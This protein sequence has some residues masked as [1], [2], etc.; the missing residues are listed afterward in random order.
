MVPFLPRFIGLAG[1]TRRGGRH[2]PGSLFSLSS[3]PLFFS[4]SLVTCS[5][6]L[7][8]K[9]GGRTPFEGD[10][11]VERSSDRDIEQSNLRSLN[12]LTQQT[13]ALQ[14]HFIRST[15]QRL[16]SSFLSRQFITPYYNLGAGNMS[17]SKLD[18]GTFRPNQYNTCV[19]L[20]HH[21]G[22]T[23]NIQ[24]YLSAV[25]NTDNIILVY[26]IMWLFWGYC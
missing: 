22:Q 3:F 8:Y 13:R 5:L 21:P 26:M 1:P 11:S 2:N 10:R 17:S 16:G 12:M 15:P 4:L 14:L 25:R 6:P 23:C 7:V 18:V 9:R 20:T 24:I 19:L